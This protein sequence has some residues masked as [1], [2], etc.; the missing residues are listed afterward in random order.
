MRLR[1]RDALH[2]PS[3]G[4]ASERPIPPLDFARR[5]VYFYPHGLQFTEA[6]PPRKGS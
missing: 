5:R 3:P 2:R 4:W 1:S 6:L